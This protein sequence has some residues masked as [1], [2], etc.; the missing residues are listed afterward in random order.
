MGPSAMTFSMSATF[1]STAWPLARL[2]RHEQ[3]FEAK[4][5]HWDAWCPLETF[6]VEAK[7]GETRLFRWIIED[8]WRSSVD[9]VVGYHN[10]VTLFVRF[11][12]LGGHGGKKG[13]GQT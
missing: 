7:A 4:D 13:L 10:L 12:V 6:Q 11:F 8:D 5:V 3:V 1:P 9:G 2:F